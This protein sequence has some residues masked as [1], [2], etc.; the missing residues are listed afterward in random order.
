MMSKLKQP[1]T[2]VPHTQK[3][4]I[5]ETS[6]FPPVKAVEVQSITGAPQ[7]RDRTD[8]Q[9]ISFMDK[10]KHVAKSVPAWFY[11]A[12]VITFFVSSLS[13]GTAGV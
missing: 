1:H 12:P 4:S 9:P 8:R 5:M 2:Q 10:V 7:L 6:P 11:L 13:F 3:A